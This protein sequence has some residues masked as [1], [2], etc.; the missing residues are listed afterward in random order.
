[1]RR[2]EADLLNSLITVII[3]IVYS[4]KMKTRSLPEDDVRVIELKFPYAV[5]CFFMKSCKMSGKVFIMVPCDV[6]KM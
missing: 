4:F 6:R 2:A 3:R 5:R 1:M